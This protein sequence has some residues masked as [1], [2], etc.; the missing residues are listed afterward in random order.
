MVRLLVVRN[1]KNQRRAPWQSIRQSCI[2]CWVISRGMSFERSCND[3]KATKG[4]E[5]CPVG[6]SSWPFFRAVNRTAL[7]D[8]VNKL[9]AGR[10]KLQQVGLGAVSRSTLADANR[11]RPHRRSSGSCFLPVPALSASG[12]RSGFRLPP[13][14]LQ[15]RCDGDRP[16]PESL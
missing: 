3:T 1:T 7:R 6:D 4:Y 11:K 15:S 10:W 5:D 16:V 8:L 2:S 14:G 9:D 12:T 13:S